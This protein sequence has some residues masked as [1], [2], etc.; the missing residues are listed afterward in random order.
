MKPIDNIIYGIKNGKT[1]TV[2]CSNYEEYYTYRNGKFYTA[3][4]NGISE[5]Y[6]KERTEEYVRTN[7]QHAL[8]NPRRYDA[9]FDFE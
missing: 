2:S 5:P 3:M 7:I 1:F 4:E 6:S 9:E 8:N